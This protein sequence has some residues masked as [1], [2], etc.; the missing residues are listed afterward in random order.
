MK[1]YASSYTH[2]HTHM[3][4]HTHTHTHMHARTHNTH[5]AHM[6]NTRFTPFHSSI[7]PPMATQRP[8]RPYHWTCRKGASNILKITVMFPRALASGFLGRER[9]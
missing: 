2:M 5:T 4:T 3:H 1:A 8:T 7:L 9:R 6:M